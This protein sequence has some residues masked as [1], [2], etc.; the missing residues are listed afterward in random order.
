MFDFELCYE[1]LSDDW[2]TRLAR[3][4][5]KIISLFKLIWRLPLIKDTLLFEFLIA[6]FGRSASIALN[7]EEK[8]DSL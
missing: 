5:F 8:E 4:Y 7:C 2:R 6:I 1:A 3:E